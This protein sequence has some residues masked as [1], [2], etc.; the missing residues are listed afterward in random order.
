M[1]RSAPLALVAV[2][3]L[4]A[5]NSKEGAGGTGE[6]AEGKPVAAVAA[7]AGQAWSDV[8]AETADGGMRMG[9]PDAPIKL[10]EYGSLSCPH[11]AKFSQDSDEALKAK[12]VD[13]GK[14]SYEYRSF[15]IHPQDVPLTVMVRC[16]P[17]EAFFG[18]V[19]QIYANFEAMN[20]PLQDQATLARAQAAMDL[21]PDK[22]WPAFADALG[23]TEFFAQR[24]VSTDQSH[25]C[26]ADVAK[27]KQ[28]ADWAQLYGDKNGVTGTPTL[29]INGNRIEGNTWAVVEPLLQRAGAR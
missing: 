25:A 1:L 6:V 8:I 13:T 19:E 16:A 26:L 10:V 28:V 22:R 21:A 5:C 3:A 17:K 18:L 12:Y 15:A 7:P 14:V 29:E 9:N 24:G 27:A 11:C 2:L 4:A 23:F 20:A